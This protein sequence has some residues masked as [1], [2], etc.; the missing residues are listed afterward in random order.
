M[1]CLQSKSSS[2]ESKTSARIRENENTGVDDVG[3]GIGGQEESAHFSGQV[4][5]SGM[6][7]TSIIDASRAPELSKYHSGGILG[8]ECIETNQ[9]L[10]CGEDKKIFLYDLETKSVVKTFTGHQKAVSQVRYAR[11]LKCAYSCSRD[12]TIKQWS[13]EG[14]SEMPVQTLE[15]HTLNIAAIDLNSDASVLASGSRDTSFVLWDTETAKQLSQVKISRN[16]VTCLKWCTDDAVCVQGSEDLRV[17]LWDCR[18]N[19]ATPAQSF[20]NGNYF[21]LGLDV[22]YC[23]NYI[24]TSSKGFN[25]VGCEV[26]VW[27]KRNLQ[28]VKAFSGHSQD[29]TGCCILDYANSRPKHLVSASKDQSIKLWDCDEDFSVE[30]FQESQ[31]GMY[32]DLSVWKTLDAHNIRF[33]ATTYFGGLYVLNFHKSTSKLSCI[34]A[35]PS[36]PFN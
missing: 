17:R 15:G 30:E 18:I 23:G 11:A 19:P 26:K 6:H 28:L 27:D 29:T 21:A 2:S 12:L 33:I 16:L 9:F 25:S 24:V 36:E 8:V 35:I 13:L 34:A 31:C 3:V 20:M 5:Q 32:T 7:E 4:P 1:G 22:S 14:E 10:T